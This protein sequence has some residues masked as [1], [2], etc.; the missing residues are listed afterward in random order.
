MLKQPHSPQ[1]CLPGSGWT[2]IVADRVTLAAGGESAE[3]NRYVASFQGQGAVVL[4]WYQTPRR[5]V[6]S[7]WSSKFFTV[8]DA[9]SV[10]RTDIALVRV[11]T[12]PTGAD[13]AKATQDGLAFAKRHPALL[14]QDRRDN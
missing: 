7:E 9:L 4:Y 10:K 1:V 6:A 12:W 14:R 8:W 5:T 11:V 13:Y 3:I 2:P